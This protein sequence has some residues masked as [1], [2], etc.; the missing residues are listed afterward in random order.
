MIDEE[1]TFQ[2]QGSASEPYRVKFLFTNGHLLASCDCPAGENGQYCKHRFRI[3]SGSQ[4]GIVSSNAHEVSVVQ[5]WF[6]GTEL[7]RAVLEVEALQRDEA[8]V[9]RRLAQAKKTVARVMVRG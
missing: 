7:E 2:V 6:K 1:R 4:E 3:L 5:G 9:K 8:E